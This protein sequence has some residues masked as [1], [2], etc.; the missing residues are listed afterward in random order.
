VPGSLDLL[1]KLDGEFALIFVESQGAT[2]G[3]AEAFAFDRGW[4]GRGAWWTKERPAST[5]LGYLPSF[6]LL[7]AEGR[8]MMKGNTAAQKSAIAEAIEDELDR[9]RK[10]PAGLDRKL[11][12]AW[13]AI[14]SKDWTKA[15]ASLEAA[16]LE[17]ELAE[18]AR[19][20]S[21]LM[22]QRIASRAAEAER[23]FEAGWLVRSLAAARS[24]AEELDGQAPWA[25]Q[26]DGL[27]TRLTSEDLE[28]SLEADEALEKLFAKICKDGI[29]RQSR[30]LASFVRKH[31]GT[32][33]AARA[34]HLAGLLDD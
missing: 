14:Q 18:Q 28:P 34:E 7:D 8:V 3:R 26:V 10:L 27:I 17:P 19:S 5:G 16:A 23:L 1:E 25:E 4:M 13:N 21:E 6:I 9:V 33:A 15:S 12:K 24:L 31:E 22:G 11:S 2:P 20:L 30:A 32:P 29:K